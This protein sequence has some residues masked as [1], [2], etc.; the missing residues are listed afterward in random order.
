MQA[1]NAP[2]YQ[3]IAADIAAKIAGGEYK[4]G[5]KIFAVPP[6]L[7]NTTFPVKQRAALFAFF[8]I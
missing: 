3:Q 2:R 7:H 5:D 4:I 1:K 6:W 8:A